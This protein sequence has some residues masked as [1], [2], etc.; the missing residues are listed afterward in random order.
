MSHEAR[1]LAATSNLWKR[2]IVAM[3]KNSDL[4]VADKH[5][6]VGKH[7]ILGCHP[8]SGLS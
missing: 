6:A 7:D 4:L 2:S 5:V 3:I 8:C 1:C